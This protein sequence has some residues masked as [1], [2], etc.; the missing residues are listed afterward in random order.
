MTD[1]WFNVKLGLTHVLDIN[2]YD[3]I[4]F[5]IALTVPYT[6]KDWKKVL[7]LV[8]VFT[9][10]H[11]ISLLLGS[12]N[13][14]AVNSAWVEFLIP[15]TILLTALFNVFTAGKGARKEKMGINFFV[16]LFF[17][18]IH[19]LGFSG[20]FRMNV[21]GRD[22]KLLTLLEFA[23]GVE[24]AQIIVVLAVLLLGFLI[25]AVFRFNK[26]DWVMVISSIVIGVA[27]PILRDTYLSL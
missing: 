6:F 17:G 25:Q 27:L 1:F 8:T 10:G 19:G 21:E 16:T 11:S 2:A 18:L 5:L 24:A 20:F 4:L 15:V 7:W 12:Y 23:L 22:N 13:V 9:I 14:I 3:H 26:R